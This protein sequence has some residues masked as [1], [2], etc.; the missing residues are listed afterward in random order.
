VVSP[1][2]RPPLAEP[3]DVA[4]RQRRL[5][6]AKQRGAEAELD[7]DELLRVLIGGDVDFV[8]IGGFAV[9]AHGYV[10]ATKDLD[11][12][13]RPDPENRETLFAALGTVDARPI[14]EGDL[15]PTEMPVEWS[16][17]ALGYGGNWA[18]AT[19]FGRIDILQYI[20]G[21]DAVETYTE[22][23]A[24]ALAIDVPDVGEVAFAGF[25]DLVLT[26]EVAGRPR[27]L[28]DLSELWQLRERTE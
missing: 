27:D 25:D 4:R 20:E 12:V 18:L 22:L 17:E 3:D 21:V 11:I 8:V 13:P 24:R 9:V 23:R 10:R 16:A 2:G 5:G 15:R 14:E 7:A 1:V 19:R 28:N 26:K 6:T